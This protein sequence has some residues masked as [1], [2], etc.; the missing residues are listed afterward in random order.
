MALTNG[1][2]QV[3]QPNVVP[4]VVDHA[5]L[6]DQSPHYIQAVADLGEEREIV[7]HEDIYA[8]NGMKL[9]AKGARINRQQAERLKMH[10]LQVPLDLVLSAEQTIDGS[11]LAADANR[12]FAED[13]VMLR[14]AER[15]GDPQGFRQGLSALTLSRPLGFRLTVMREK[16]NGLYRHT[17]RVAL[18]THAMAVRLDL[19]EM[20]KHDVLLAALCHD[21]GE[22][23]TDPE[24]LASDHRI[25]SEQRRFIHVHP[26]TS[27]VI[28]QAMPDI[29]SATLQAVLH[30]H[31]RIDGSGYPHGLTESEIHPL[32]KLLC[33]AEVMVGVVRRADRHRL[34][35]ILRL[36]QQRFDPAVLGVLRDLLRIGDS[37]KQAALPECDPSVHLTHVM[38]VIAAWPG[39][40]D[41]LAAQPSCG[42]SLG[43]LNER[44]S[45]LRSLVLQVGIDPENAE[46]LLELA[47]GEREILIELHAT[48]DEL[49]WMMI[50]IANEAE[51]RT[52][53]LDP[54][55]RSIV[56]KLITVL[57][58][59]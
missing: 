40:R 20:E 15:S 42:P 16:R 11:M 52:A 59:G 58:L 26:I 39:V 12:M 48:L 45:L 7:A 23:H 1:F 17:L 31:E 54:L 32:A 14:L 3:V 55:T 19:T 38:A 6:P 49:H 9:L 8:S 27:Y 4:L 33:V 13:P 46:M 36:N 25:T 53:L 10:K 2:P 22:M 21:L 35:V 18:I 51:R 41:A 29:P 47:R 5:A 28:L 34:D 57:R 43:F 24:L 37:E 44:M 56:F 50:D 30:H